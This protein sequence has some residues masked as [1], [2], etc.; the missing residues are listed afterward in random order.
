MVRLVL[1]KTMCSGNFR[2]IEN[3]HK[4]WLK[5]RRIKIN[6]FNL[7]L[8]PMRKLGLLSDT[9]GFLDKDIL[10]FLSICDEILHAGDIGSMEVIDSLQ[11]VKPLRAV[12]GLSLI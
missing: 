10:A 3:M 8:K 2:S 12:Y 6:I 9:H 1:R 7:Y 11:S 4:V 5:L